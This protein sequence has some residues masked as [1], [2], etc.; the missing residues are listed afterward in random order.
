MDVN[1]AGTALLV[2]SEVF[3]PGWKAT[4]N[5]QPAEIR[6][7]DGALRGIVVPGG[8]SHVVMEYSPASFYTGI[9]LS[10]LTTAC[11]MI[12]WILLWR[13]RRPG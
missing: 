4:V 12:A 8:F 5:G 7:T 11:V 10:L 3:Y 6:K 13:R 1:T 9:G 2:V